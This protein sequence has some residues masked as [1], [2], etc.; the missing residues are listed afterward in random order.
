ID[1][2]ALD[3]GDPNTLYGR[4]SYAGTTWTAYDDSC[5][6]VLPDSVQDPSNS[7]DTLAGNY[8]FDVGKIPVA[9]TNGLW[10]QIHSQDTFSSLD[11]VLSKGA[12]L[13]FNGPFTDF[14]GLALLLAVVWILF[15]VVRGDMARIATK[16]MW[17]MVALWLAASASLM[18]TVYTGVLDNL[19]IGTMNDVQNSILQQSNTTGGRNA[20]PEML[21]NSVV[22]NTWQ[23]GEFGQANATEAQKFTKPLIDSQAWAKTDVSSPDDQAKFAAK[24][25]EFKD[26]NTQLKQTSVYQY[27]TGSAGQ[28]T[29]AG[30]LGAA[31]GLSFSLFPAIAEIG[32]WLGILLLRLLVLFGPILGLVIILND[33]FAP[34][35]M[36]GLGKALGSCLFLTVGATGEL[37]LLKFVLGFN[38]MTI[39]Q[40]LLLMAAITVIAVIVVKPMRQLQNIAGGITS[41]VGLQ[42]AGDAIAGFRVPMPWSHDRRM[43]RALRKMTRQGNSKSGGL[44]DFWAERGERD[45]GAQHT[46][47]RPEATGEPLRAKAERVHADSADPGPLRAH[48][49]RVR[50]RPRPGR[51]PEVIGASARTHRGYRPPS[52]SPGDLGGTGAGSPGGGGPS[53]L[54]SG[55][56]G[57]A[58]LPPGPTGTVATDSSEPDSD[59]SASDHSTGS[60]HRPVRERPIVPTEYERDKWLDAERADTDPPHSPTYEDED[61]GTVYQIF[62]PNTN[63]VQDRVVDQDGGR[64]ESDPESDEEGNR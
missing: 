18:P 20:V 31:R 55:G 4:Y 7:F 49:E 33:K 19:L 28:R 43:M 25:Q 10:Y 45:P 34:G 22:L 11:S 17:I 46:K 9:I 30:I 37:W 51:R 13:M 15:R 54:G 27:F 64:S 63:E 39:F 38:D 1:P 56:G 32:Q 61:G 57:A 14:V 62:M 23:Q 36:R 44:V 58:A 35:M 29:G 24:Q 48:A 52:G 6:S 21:Y 40:Q 16:T 59:H 42:E 3:H 41:A 8:L 53:G 60:G 26:V 2:P 5:S 12:A 47:P 50:H